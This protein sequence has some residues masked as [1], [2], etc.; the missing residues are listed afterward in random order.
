MRGLDEGRPV[1]VT[2]FSREYT[3]K[4]DAMTILVLLKSRV[5]ELLAR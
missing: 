3:E 5:A 1:I 4:T 2:S